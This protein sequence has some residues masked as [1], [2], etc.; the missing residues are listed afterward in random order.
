MPS[1]AARSAST[2]GT[3]ATRAVEH[4]RLLKLYSVLPSAKKG[5]LE[6]NAWQAIYALEGAPTAGRGKTVLL[7]R[8]RQ[9]MAG[10]RELRSVAMP[11]FAF[12]DS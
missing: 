9:K 2:L 3:K 7:A 5:T 6:H 10:H 11:L 12:I 1:S 8:M 4:A